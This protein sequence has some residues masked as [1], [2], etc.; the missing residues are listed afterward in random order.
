MREHLDE[1]HRSRKNS[2]PDV[3][4]KSR[5][6]LVTWCFSVCMLSRF[7]LTLICLFSFWPGVPTA[8]RRSTS[9]DVPTASWPR[10]PRE[11]LC[12]RL[13]PLCT[14]NGR[15]KPPETLRKSALPSSSPLIKFNVAWNS[16]EWLSDQPIKGSHF[17][18]D[19]ALSCFTQPTSKAFKYTT[20]ALSSEWDATG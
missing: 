15:L 19:E 12:F 1:L 8:Y 4:L 16:I 6:V 5:R 14:S 10:Q 11:H 13:R 18:R 7:H 17:H 9:S 3:S 20:T 2:C